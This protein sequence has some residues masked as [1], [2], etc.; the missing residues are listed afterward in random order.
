MDARR[1]DALARALFAQGSRRRLLGAFVG[2]LGPAVVPFGRQRAA[3]ACD[4][5]CPPHKPCCIKGTCRP[6]CHNEVCCADCFAPIIGPSGEPDP[7]R[8]FCCKPGKVCLGKKPGKADD[9]CCY[10]S[11]KCVKGVCCCHF[12]RGA[13]K[14]GGKCCA[15]EACCNGACCP[16][17]KVC[18]KKQIGD[19]ATCVSTKRACG[20]PGDP[21]CFVAEKCVGGVC[22]KNNLVCPL[23]AAGNPGPGGSPVCCRAHEWCD[24]GGPENG[25]RCCPVNRVCNT[26]RSPRVR[27]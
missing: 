10:D 5:P 11:E 8:T 1:F 13:Q 6:Y 22:C 9:R 17:G 24:R 4:G 16:K 15:I 23:D 25:H 20:D 12:C 7:T 27:S 26:Y 14:C 2:F 18:A 3:A 21:A 19:P